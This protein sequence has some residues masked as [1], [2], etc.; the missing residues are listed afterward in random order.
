MTKITLDQMTKLTGDK[1]VM[2][3]A[4]SEIS[5]ENASTEWVPADAD[6]K[7]RVHQTV[8]CWGVEVPTQHGKIY[9]VFGSERAARAYAAQ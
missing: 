9:F 1:V 7:T 6:I 5:A 2:F 4:F 3:G 8:E